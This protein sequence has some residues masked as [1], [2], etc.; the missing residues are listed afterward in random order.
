MV[1]H[2]FNLAFVIQALFDV[3]ANQSSD[4]V[5]YCEFIYSA[6]VMGLCVCIG[7]IQYVFAQHGYLS[8]HTIEMHGF[9]LQ[10]ESRIDNVNR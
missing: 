2:V 5:R 9:A 10:I 1:P 6:Y 4:C 3:M 7:D 8:L